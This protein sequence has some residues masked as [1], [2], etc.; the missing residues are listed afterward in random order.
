MA[1]G[2]YKIPEQ[3]I[4]GR[5]LGRHLHH[6]ERSRGFPAQTADVIISVKHNGK[7]LPLNQG[8]IGSCTAEALCAALNCDP[9]QA[10][11]SGAMAG[12]LFTQSDALS[13]YGTE[14]AA[15]GS[16]YP[17]DDIGG[18]GLDVCAAA[19]QLGWIS[20]Y[21]WTFS[22]EDAL[23]ALVIRPLICGINWYASFD[24]PDPATGV[25]T[26]SKD[27]TI[28]GGHEICADEIDADRQLIGFWQSW[29]PGWGLNGTG[30]FYISFA[31]CE[32]LLAE[33]GDV[34]VPVP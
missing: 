23:K 11:L 7:G 33:G 3:K 27:P 21:T 17:P 20:S 2:R 19:K 1:F 22:A 26:F 14:T 16:P 13:L 29:G 12:H 4:E 31:D 34:A 10:A 5:R 6:D 32:R 25:C 9:N 24:T 15:E 18:T 28:R 8:N 30:R